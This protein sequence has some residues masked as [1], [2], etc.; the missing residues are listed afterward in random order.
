MVNH[1][2]SVTKPTYQSLNLFYTNLLTSVSKLPSP[3]TYVERLTYFLYFYRHWV[4]LRVGS[5]WSRLLLKV[6]VHLSYRVRH[7]SLVEEKGRWEQEWVTRV[8]VSSVLPSLPPIHTSIVL[9]EVLSLL[10]ILTVLR[11]EE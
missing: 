1:Q 6:L 8:F 7:L 10:L 9:P 4:H 5:H 11:K 3:C 2:T